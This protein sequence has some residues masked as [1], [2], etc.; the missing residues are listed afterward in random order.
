[1]RVLGGMA[2]LGLG[3]ASIMAATEVNNQW[4]ILARPSRSSF[5]LDA[6]CVAWLRILHPDRELSIWTMNYDTVTVYLENR[7]RMAHITADFELIPDQATLLQ[8]VNLTAILP[9]YGIT[10]VES[11]RAFFQ[12]NGYVPLESCVD[13]TTGETWLWQREQALDYA[14]SLPLSVAQSPTQTLPKS[15]TAPIAGLSHGLDRVGLVVEGD[16]NASRVVVIQELAYPGWGVWI[17]GA[18]ATVESVGGLLGVIVPPGD[19]QRL[20]RF[21]YIPPLLYLGAGITLVTWAVCALFLLR[22]ERLLPAAWLA[23]WQ[24][25]AAR[26]RHSMTA[27]EGRI[28][29]LARRTGDFLT[30]PGVLDEA[31]HRPQTPLLPAPAEPESMSES[32][33]ES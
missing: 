2:A 24:N 9:E 19:G 6:A 22:A 8:N 28:S 20:I 3:F 12:E 17:D 25:V 16:P 18:P 15:A 23:R 29:V 13:P 7:V 31:Y 21:Q 33:T 14:F 26:V 10:W 27:P 4:P 11:V 30:D 5:T 32:D 1:M